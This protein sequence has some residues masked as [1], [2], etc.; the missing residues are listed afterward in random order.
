MRPI[1]TFNTTIDRVEMLISLNELLCNTRKKRIRA[2]WARNFKQWMK[3][4]RNENI[5]RIDS[6]EAIIILREHASVSVDR[7]CEEDLSELLRAAL[8]TSVSSLDRYIHELVISKIM[9]ELNKNHDDISSELKKMEISLLGAVEA[10]K[11]A[12]KTSEK[13]RP[14]TRI[15]GILQDKLFRYTYQ[16]PKEIEQA[17]NMVGIKS[18]W[19]EC[20]AKMGCKAEDIKKRLSAIINRRNQIVHEGDLIKFRRGGK[21][22]LNTIRLKQTRD[23]VEWLK[24]LVI[25]IDTLWGV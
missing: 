7:F 2:D 25:T 14:M 13:T 23:D 19:S 15:K 5:H 4:P 10:V 18:I 20:S 17:L 9:T 21:P 1:D 22:T 6:N 8:V 24:N 11:H 16:Q 12:R 3:W